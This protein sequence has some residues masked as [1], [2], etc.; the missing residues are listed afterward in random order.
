[1][2][3]SIFKEQEMA[4]TKTTRADIYA[5]VTNSIVA[6]IER[7]AT[8]SQWQLP[9]HKMAHGLPTNATTQ[10]KYSGVNILS[11]WVAAELRGF[12]S[13]KWAT[14]KQWELVGAQVRKGSKSSLIV[15]YKQL[16]GRRKIGRFHRE[17]RNRPHRHDGQGQPCFQRRPG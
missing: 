8:G 7:G 12:G 14:Y 11:L 6:A 10:K 17:R 4:T 13:S 1:M 15:F 3:Q 9:W 5:E 2:N 16:Q